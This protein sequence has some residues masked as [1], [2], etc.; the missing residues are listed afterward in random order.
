MSDWIVHCEYAFLEGGLTIDEVDE[1]VGG[2]V[3]HA[4]GGVRHAVGNGPWRTTLAWVFPSLT[5]AVAA[6]AKLEASR[7]IERVVLVPTEETRVMSPDEYQI[8]RSDAQAGHARCPNCHQRIQIDEAN[9]FAL[10][11]VPPGSEAGLRCIACDFS[12]N[13]VI[14]ADL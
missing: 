8:R 4:A 9:W 12:M 10:E 6:S 2:H 7:G 11:G 3:D 14:L 5:D 1:L 13:W